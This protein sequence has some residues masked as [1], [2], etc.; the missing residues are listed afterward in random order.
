MDNI[1]EI[2]IP[3]LIAAVYFFGNAFSGKSK[4]DE[5]GP[6]LRPRE[7]DA[8]DEADPEALERQRRIQEEIRRKIME[9]RQATG[10]EPPQFA[11]AESATQEGRRDQAMPHRSEPRVADQARQSR[12]EPPPMREQKPGAFSWDVS[13]DAYDS[14][15]QAQLKRIEATKRQAEKLQ[16]QARAGREKSKAIEK[17]KRRSGGYLTGTVRESLQ[18]PHA[19]RV[20]FIYGEV[21]GPP[22]SLR[23]GNSSVPGLS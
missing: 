17:P 1:F 20:A 12:R 9:R 23:K 4:E 13:D 7:R 11:P 19:A 5:G 6:P 2:L 10:G 14:K 21:L 15:M 16:K 22:I 18:D 3:L 8:E